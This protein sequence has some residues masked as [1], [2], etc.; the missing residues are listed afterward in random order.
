M[1]FAPVPGHSTFEGGLSAVINRVHVDPVRNMELIDV[2]A[3]L[4][5]GSLGR[6][7]LSV[8]GN[9]VGWDGDDWQRLGGASLSG[10]V[11][12]Q[13]HEYYSGTSR[14]A[15]RVYMKGPGGPGGQ[16]ALWVAW[17]DGHSWSGPT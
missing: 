13:Q 7:S 2:F 4:S 9:E 5:D 14:P 10:A 1:P 11:A 8:V 17:S 16:Q 6:T 3:C 12:V 15:H